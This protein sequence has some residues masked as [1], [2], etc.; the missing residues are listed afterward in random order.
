DE[1]YFDT[2]NL[3]L[4]RGRALNREDGRPGHESAVINQRLATMYF[5]GEDPIGRRVKLT[6]IPP[7]P[8]EEWTTIVGIA[9][10][11]RQRFIREP[12]PDPIVYLPYRA[13][14]QRSAVLMLRTTADP[15]KVTASVREALHVVEP[16]LPL[17]R[18]QT[19]SQLLGRQRWPFQVFGMMFAVFAGI[20]LILSSV[21]LYAVT[22]YS[23]TQRTQEIG[24]R[25]AL[26]AQPRGVLWLVLRRA[27]IQLSI[28]L[29]L[30]IAG[31]FGVGKIL[32]SILI[33]TNAGDPLT[34]SLVVLMLVIVALLATAA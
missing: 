21:G 11:V 2:L 20:A 32:Q 33:Q 28:G 16:D 9:P 24:I 10:T 7:G 25:M 5:P 15:G 8:H 19:M 22:A 29:T 31:A 18:I 27:L 30:G 4:A 34:L 14:P 1:T 17:F 3:K 12:Q 26:G 6:T 13:D 23:V